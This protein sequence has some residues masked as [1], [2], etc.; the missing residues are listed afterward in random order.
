MKSY[1]R[2][3]N[4][5]A[6]M[7][8]RCNNPEA[9][10]YRSYGGRGIRVC[11]RWAKFDNFL[12]D[13]GT[14]PS[15]AHTLDRIDNE[16]DYTPQNCRWADVEK[17]QNNRRNCIHV[18]AFGETKTIAQWARATG[19]SRDMVQHRLYV[20]KMEPEVALIA[21]RMSW[22]QR[23]VLQMDLQGNVLQRFESL[24]AVRAQYGKSASSVWN[25]L[26]GKAK[27]AIGFRWRYEN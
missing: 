22:N 14:A 27:T 6:M 26:A 13:M 4:I 19:L 24:A 23:A 10:N 12:A 3:Y 18:T 16:G 11:E 5:W 17:Q 9:K 1:T 21:E 20:M 8:Q 7:R 2:E 25:A 15:P